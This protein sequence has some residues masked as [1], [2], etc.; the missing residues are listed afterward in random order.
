MHK[1]LS[2]KARIALILAGIA[3]AFATRIGL[4]ALIA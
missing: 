2:A 1:T 3:A 4:V